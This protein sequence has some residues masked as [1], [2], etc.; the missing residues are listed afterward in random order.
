MSPKVSIIIPTYNRLDYLKKS[1][2]CVLRQTYKDYEL[3]ISD[4]F[5]EDGTKSWGKEMAKKFSTIKYYRNEKNL[6]MVENWNSGLRHA[7]GEYVS[8]LMSDDYWN[9]NFLKETVKVLENKKNVGLVCVYITSEY[10]SNITE[11]KYSKNLF[12]L[13]DSDREIKGLNCIKQFLKEGWLVGNP[14]GILARRRCFLELGV[15]KE[16]VLD[17]EM[18]LRICSKFD[19]YYLDKN[20]AHWRIHKGSFSSENNNPILKSFRN[21]RIFDSILSYEYSFDE[22]KKIIELRN[23]AVKRL[24]LELLNYFPEILR[25]KDLHIKDAISLYKLYNPVWKIYLDIFTVV[26]KHFTKKYLKQ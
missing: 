25:R 17:P 16:F 18:W 11:R 13:Y 1:V 12:K 14:S 6:G 9:K 8:I 7:N 4:N 5:S 15:F 26:V 2:L 10:S 21:Y 3:I 23:I 22:L 24:R 20:L 19:F